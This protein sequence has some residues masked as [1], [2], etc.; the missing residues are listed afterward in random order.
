MFRGHMLD[1]KTLAFALT[2]RGLS[3]EEPA[4]SS[5]SSTASRRSNA[6]ASLRR[7][8][9]AITGATCSRPASL[10][11]KL[12]AEYALHPI[13][14]QV[15]KAYSPASIG[16][17]YLRGDGNH[18]DAHTYAGLSEAVSRVCSESAFYRRSCERAR[19]QSCR[20]RSSTLTSSGSIPR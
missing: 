11:E 6:T 9:S 16:K 15:T 7:S 3:L 18:A 2:D 10:R 17:A 5:A 12:L 13:P 14:L 20:C 1:A 4:S 8:T 19:A